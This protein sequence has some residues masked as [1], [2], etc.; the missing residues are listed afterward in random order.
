MLGYIVYLCSEV[1]CKGRLRNL[2][3]TRLRFSSGIEPILVMCLASHKVSLVF[4]SFPQ[5]RHVTFA[6]LFLSQASRSKQPFNSGILLNILPGEILSFCSVTSSSKP[7]AQILQM[8]PQQ[9]K[10]GPYR[11][12]RTYCGKFAVKQ[13][14]IPLSITNEAYRCLTK[15]KFCQKIR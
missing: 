14:S 6:H 15:P 8:I 13:L 5:P 1:P 12:L 3:S 4:I 9:L 2:C 7:G 11:F 10:V